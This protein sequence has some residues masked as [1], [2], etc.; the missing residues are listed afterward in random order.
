[1]T[2]T[3]HLLFIVAAVVCFLVGFLIGVDV[4]DGDQSPWLFGG[5]GLF[6]AS[7]LP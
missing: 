3:R 4:F 5:L 7:Q 6:A 1:M 2:V